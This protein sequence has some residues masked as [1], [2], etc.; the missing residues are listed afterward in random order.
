MQEKII[1]EMARK[2]AEDVRKDGGHLQA[3]GAWSE[4]FKMTSNKTETH[5]QLEEEL[6]ALGIETI[7]LYDYAD[8]Y[9]PYG[10]EETKRQVYIKYYKQI[11]QSVYS[12]ITQNYERMHREMEVIIH[13]EKSSKEKH[14]RAWPVIVDDETD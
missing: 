6:K 8:L 7:K 2:L 13:S 3:F 14:L 1:K 12:S 11:L 10:I 4:E 5:E 9:L